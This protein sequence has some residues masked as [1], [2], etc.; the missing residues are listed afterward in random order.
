MDVKL[1][2]ILAAALAV[3]IGSIGPAL[4]E[5]RSVAAAMDAI[6]RGCH[7]AG[8]LRAHGHAAGRRCGRKPTGPIG[9]GRDSRA[10]D[11]Q[12][13]LVRRLPVHGVR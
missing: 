1:I 11:G 9:P 8:V 3:S 7:H 4:A 6:A 5:G 13:I 2:S 12:M 10:R